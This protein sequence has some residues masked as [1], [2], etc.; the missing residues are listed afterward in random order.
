MDVEIKQEKNNDGS[1]T[2]SHKLTNEPIAI[3]R[4]AKR[5][6]KKNSVDVEW[7]PD[8]KLIH[9]LGSSLLHGNY[10]G[11]ER[12]AAHHESLSSASARV[13]GIAQSI[14]NEQL[15][16]DPVKTS[17]AGEDVE[18][19]N[20]GTE[21]KIHKWNVHDD[22]GEIIGKI[23]S[24]EGPNTIHAN[25]Q[26]SG[27]L[28]Q[29]YANKHNISSDVIESANKKHSGN[30]LEHIMNRFRYIQDKKGKEPRFIGTERSKDASNDVYKTK[31]QPEEASK[32]Y[33]DVLKKKLGERFTFTR[34]SPT[35]F[36]AHKP[37]SGVYD[38]SET[39][40][41][42]SMPGELH[43]VVSRADHPEYSGAKKNTNIIES[44]V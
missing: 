5:G 25:Q 12:G 27:K 40:H 14:Y 32:A 9:N 10:S 7:H 3:V 38:S 2:L 34:H 28:F 8:F 13:S 4:P 37:A 44:K 41:I 43:H 31:L 35:A 23:H 6:Y 17:Y 15:K 11:G 36:M 42:I 21:R 16:P 30:T 29:D 19:D 39:H 24:Y 20:Y 1:V 26:V 18:K 33:E 22:D